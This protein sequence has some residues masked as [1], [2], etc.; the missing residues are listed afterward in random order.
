MD[1][2]SVDCSK[3]V[4]DMILEIQ[5]VNKSVVVEEKGLEDLILPLL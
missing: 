5:E 3:K 4:V 2:A 1:L